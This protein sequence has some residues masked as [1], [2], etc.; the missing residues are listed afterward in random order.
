MI[1]CA[2]HGVTTRVC[3]PSAGVPPPPGQEIV[4]RAIN[5][6][7]KSVELGV[8]VA[9]RSTMPLD[10]AD[11]G[12]FSQKPSNTAAAVGINHLAEMTY[13]L[14]ASTAPGLTGERCDVAL[15]ESR[16]VYGGLLGPDGENFRFAVDVVRALN[17]HRGD[18]DRLR[19]WHDLV[20]GAFG[21]RS[22]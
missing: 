7:E 15:L 16:P 12:L 22:D 9:S 18:R 17:L 1:D 5:G 11:F 6:H 8:H 13:G 14:H 21:L 20:G 10:T 4:R 19:Q 2:T 3:D